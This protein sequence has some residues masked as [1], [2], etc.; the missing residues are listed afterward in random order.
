MVVNGLGTPEQIGEAVARIKQRGGRTVDHHPAD[1][2]DPEQIDAMIASIEEGVGPVDI[3]IN[4]AGIQ[5]TARIEDFPRQKWDDI[6][7]VNLSSAF[8]ATAQ[9]LPGMRIRDYGRI[10]NIA[11]VHGLVASKEKA[12]YVA[13]KHGIVGLT[14]VT[15]LE[16]AEANITCNAICPAFTL[17]PLVQAQIDKRA[18]DQGLSNEAATEVL[19]KEKEPSLRFTKTGEIAAAVLYLLSPAGNNMTGSCLTMDGGWTAQ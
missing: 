12:A 15:A 9:V 14:K 18:D 4:N 11:S 2:R 10:I 1:L 13:A 7:A 6:L 3:L 16:N 8:H 5:H 19:L 17:T